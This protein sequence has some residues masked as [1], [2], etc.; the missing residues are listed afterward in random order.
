M[1][2]MFAALAALVLFAAPVAAQDNPPPSLEANGEGIVMTVPDIAIVTIGVTTRAETASAALSAN[3]ADLAKV[4]ATVTGEGVADKDIGTSGF[5]IYPVYEQLPEQPAPGQMPKIV[6]YQ[7]QNE[8]RVTIRDIAKSGGILDRVVTAGANQVNGISFDSAD[9]KT[10]AEAALKD[11]IADAR[12]KAEIMAAAAG[13]R[14]V[15]IL[16]VSASQGGGP[17][18]MFAR[19]ELSAQKDVPVMPGQQQITANATVRWEIAPQ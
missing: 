14:L 7:V 15:R 12:R 1:K 10:P 17:Q 16:Q 19:M 2:P 9:R 8:V 11:A 18:P 5:S 3:S 6:G 13:V 4:I